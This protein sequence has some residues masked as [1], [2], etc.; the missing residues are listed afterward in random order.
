[1]ASFKYSLPSFNCTNLFFKE[2]KNTTIEFYE[3]AKKFTMIDL[4][5]VERTKSF[6]QA[7]A[8]YAKE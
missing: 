5:L 1:V 3:F 7:L 4:P 6:S 8:K 2:Y